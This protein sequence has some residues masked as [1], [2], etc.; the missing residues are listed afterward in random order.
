MNEEKAYKILWVKPWVSEGDLWRAFRK[1]SK[2]KHPDRGGTEEAF[3]ELTDARNLIQKIIDWELRSNIEKTESPEEIY[4]KRLFHMLKEYNN[5]RKQ[6]PTL[7]FDQKFCIQERRICEQIWKTK[8]IGFIAKALSLCHS[9]YYVI[10]IN[11]LLRIGSFATQKNL[12][13]ML[14]FCIDAELETPSLLYNKEFQILKWEIKK[15]S[16]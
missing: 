6:N 12:I 13:S 15:L 3:K 16:H 5:L 11:S 8:N 7:S 4:A 10:L 2:N 9:D 1:E 14:N